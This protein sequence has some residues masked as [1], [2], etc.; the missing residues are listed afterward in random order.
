MYVETSSNNHGADHVIVSWE[1][2]DII[3]TCNIKF[4]FNIFSTSDQNLRGMGR[5]GIQLLLEDNSWSTIYNVPKNIQFSNGS[6]QWHLFVMDI[7]HENN[8]TKFVYDEIPTALTDMC[9]SNIILT[10]SVYYELIILFKPV[11]NCYVFLNI[12]EYK[13]NVDVNISI[14]NGECKFFYRFVRMNTRF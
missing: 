12:P 6:T 9:F 10:H 7:T 1:G 5:F 13:K 3:Q 2:S 4:Y 8:G 14:S 11:K